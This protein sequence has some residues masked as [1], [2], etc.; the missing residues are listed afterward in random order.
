MKTRST[1]PET[2]AIAAPTAFATSK[3]SGRTMRD[4]TLASASGSST[5]PPPT[6]TTGTGS[7]LVRTRSMAS[8]A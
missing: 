4:A 7:T 6:A 8:V 3:C 5:L 1:S 2:S